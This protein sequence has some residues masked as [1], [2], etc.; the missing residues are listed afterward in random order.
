[1]NANE[2]KAIH[3]LSQDQ[4]FETEIMTMFNKIKATAV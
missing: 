3:I 2:V 4:Q 1:M